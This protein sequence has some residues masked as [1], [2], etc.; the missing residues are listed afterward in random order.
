MFGES[1]AVFVVTAFM[2]SFRLFYSFGPDESDHNNQIENYLAFLHFA[3]AS[4]TFRRRFFG[5]GSSYYRGR[6]H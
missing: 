1:G 5:I 4:I 6:L 3:L 2:R